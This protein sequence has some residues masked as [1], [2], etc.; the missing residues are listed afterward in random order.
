MRGKECKNTGRCYHQLRESIS[1]NQNLLCFI[2]ASRTEQGP[3]FILTPDPS[4]QWSR[5]DARWG[6]GW[7]VSSLIFRH[8][9]QL[10]TRAHPRRYLQ[11]SGE[12]RKRSGARRKK[13]A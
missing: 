6:T 1:Q 4:G 7:G 8:D 10:H 12:I 2:S 9:D 3:E 5:P 13:R 11:L